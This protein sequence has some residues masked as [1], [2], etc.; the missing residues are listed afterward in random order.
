M[1]E[2]ERLRTLM[3]MHVTAINL[4]GLIE[5]A[6]FDNRPFMGVMAAYAC[7]DA[8]AR[9]KWLDRLVKVSEEEAA[10]IQ[11]AMEQRLSD[12]LNELGAPKKDEWAEEIS[13]D[14]DG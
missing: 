8:A 5:E 4:A 9:E 12:L 6:G 2:L 7:P 13:V 10:V 3:Q 14:T 11:P 1:D